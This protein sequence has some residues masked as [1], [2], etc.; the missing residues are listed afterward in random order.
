M[1]NPYLERCTYIATDIDVDG[2]SSRTL[3]SVV[4]DD[5]GGSFTFRQQGILPLRTLA[6]EVLYA[7][8]KL[9]ILDRRNVDYRINEE[10]SYIG[11]L[12]TQSPN[13]MAYVPDFMNLL[14]VEGSDATGILT[15]D[16]SA[17]GQF[18]VRSMPA[19]ETVRQLLR[20]SMAGTTG[21]GDVIRTMTCDQSVAFSAGGRER[22]LDFTPLPVAT[23]QLRKHPAYRQAVLDTQ[24]Q[25]P[26]I[27]ITIPNASP[28]GRSIQGL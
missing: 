14:V 20:L 9:P 17:G 10:L 8:V 24:A 5:S 2:L 3:G 13:L 1:T 23:S 18:E 16:A 6:E 12:S 22:L 26:D 21:T 7:G 15:E 11:M 28:L 19:S 27:T 4:G 25:L